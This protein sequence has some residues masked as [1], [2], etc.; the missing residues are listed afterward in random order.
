MNEF[1]ESLTGWD[2]ALIEKEFGIAEYLP[3]Q[4]HPDE[5]MRTLVFIA[6]MRRN[7]RSIAQAKAIAVGML[8][9]D[10]EGYWRETR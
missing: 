4:L 5:L 1:L 8:A 7:D 3:S 10:L 2:E 9:S 6:E